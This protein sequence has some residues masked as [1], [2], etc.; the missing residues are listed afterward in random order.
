MKSV[1]APIR[2]TQVLEV[3]ISLAAGA[4]GLK[5]AYDLGTQVA[6]LWLGLI[7]G[8]NAGLFCLLTASFL[9]DR[10]FR[11]KPPKTSD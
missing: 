6:G 10:I 1:S 7:M 8:F 4:I 2:W 9:T 3:V 11:R 5:L